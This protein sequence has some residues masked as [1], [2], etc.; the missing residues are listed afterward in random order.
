MHITRAALLPIGCA[1][2]ATVIGCS[3]DDEPSDDPKETATL[4]L[5]HMVA[6]DYPKACL[7][8]VDDNYKPLQEGTEDFTECV[9]DQT[10]NR[11][12]GGI[13]YYQEPLDNPMKVEYRTDEDGHKDADVDI[14]GESNVNVTLVDDVWYITDT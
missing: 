1:L 14:E 4:Y 3:S 11:A 6:G 9:D 5:K 13:E 7:L 10:A 2:L 8:F 12:L